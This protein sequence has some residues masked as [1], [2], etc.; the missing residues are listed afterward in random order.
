M[1]PISEP[2]TDVGPFVVS[3]PVPPAINSTPPP[4]ISCET[5]K[6]PFAMLSFLLPCVWVLERNRS[7]KGE[8][9]LTRGR[10]SLCLI[11]DATAIPPPPLTIPLQDE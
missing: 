7:Y 5:P 9:V 8:V 3:Q 4:T 11:E 6:I 1:P 10:T 2:G